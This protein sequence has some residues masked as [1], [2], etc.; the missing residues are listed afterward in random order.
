MAERLTTRDFQV[1][2]CNQFVESLTEPANTSYFMF[3]G[4]PRAWTNESQPLV[5][6]DSEQTLSFDTWDSMVCGKAL[7]AN[8][9]SLM[10]DRY[11]WVVNTV[12][13]MY[14]NIEDQGNSNFFVITQQS[15][16]YYVFKCLY[17]NNGLPSTVTPSFS[18]TSA[19][20]IFYATADGYQWK[21][22]YTLD[23]ATYNNFTTNLYIPVTPDANVT[24]NAV[25]GAIDVILVETSGTNYNSYANGFFQTVSVG[26]N[27]LAHAIDKSSS[28]NNDFYTS[29]SIKII[30][31]KG[32]G[33]QKTITEYDVSG[34][35]KTV[36]ID[37]AWTNVPDVTSQYEIMPNIQIIGDG[38]GAQARGIVDT[39]S[40]SIVYAEITQRG[41]GYSW[42]T[43]TAQGNTGFISNTVANNATLRTIIGPPGGH[44]SDLSHELSTVRLGISVSFANTEGGTIPATNKFRTFGLIRDPLFANVSLTLTSIVGSFQVGETITTDTFSNS[45]VTIWNSGTSTLTVTDLVGKIN[46]GDTIVGVTSNTHAT[47]SNTFVS[48]YNKNLNTFD[49]RYRFNITLNTSNTFIQNEQITQAVTAA[50]GYIHEANTTFVALTDTKGAFVVT[51]HSE[52][53]NDLNGVSANV[54]TIHTP[55]II[56]SSGKVLYLENDPPTLTSNSSTTRISLVIGF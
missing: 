4:H 33:Q 22:L 32:A 34:N 19:D 46:P 28:S 14:D 40:N 25:P 27:P 43:A 15:S 2:M 42:A 29:S 41:Q 5:P 53:L 1:H 10:A 9:L 36:I 35:T 37:S 13:D 55:D 3:L 50:N 20:D 7:V 30:Q 8:N 18:D 21:Y 56:K 48:G 16:T 49:N 31:G 52:L 17:N 45:V 39:S 51:S 54:V 26:G 6:V 12:Y 47:V 11:D 38:T 24:G 44:G 23:S